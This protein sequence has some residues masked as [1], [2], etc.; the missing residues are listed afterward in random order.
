MG[1]LL[2]ALGLGAK[3]ASVDV[4]GA[5]VEVRMGWA[6]RARF[7]RTSVTAAARSDRRAISQGVHGRNGHWLV[8]GAKWGLVR[9]DLAPGEEAH[10][11]GRRV[12]LSTLEVSIEDPDA[13]LTALSATTESGG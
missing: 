12:A 8:N 11:L 5:A 4:D 13:L 3:R 9:V 2:G 6:F 7:P 10:V 1:L